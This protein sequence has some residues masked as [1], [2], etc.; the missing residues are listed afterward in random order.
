MTN[1]D[2]AQW[3][4]VGLTALIQLAG[5]FYQQGQLADMA[6]AMDA[7][8]IRVERVF[9]EFVLRGIEHPPDLEH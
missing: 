2:K 7:R 9:D 3:A 4:A 5:L 1:G 6:R 8:L